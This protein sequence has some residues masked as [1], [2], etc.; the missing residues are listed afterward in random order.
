MY[1]PA[2]PPWNFENVL[3]LSAVWKPLFHPALSE[4]FQMN[5]RHASGQN[6]PKK[7]STF[8]STRWPEF[9]FLCPP[10]KQSSDSWCIE[11]HWF[12][13]HFQISVTQSLQCLLCLLF[14]NR[15]ENQFCV[16][17]LERSYSCSEILYRT[18]KFYVGGFFFLCFNPVQHGHTEGS[19]EKNPLNLRALPLRNAL[20]KRRM[21]TVEQKSN[22]FL[23]ER[24]N[25]L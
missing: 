1:W 25:V 3:L 23:L 24:Q 11:F 12:I 19:L 13:Q 18:S 15:W 8:L 22:W 2:P 20:G 17:F 5:F 9:R 14:I 10:E 7:H 6:P 16:S 4:I 21:K